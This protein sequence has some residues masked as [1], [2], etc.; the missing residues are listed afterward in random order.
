MRPAIPPVAE[1]LLLLVLLLIAYCVLYG[2]FGQREVFVVLL[3]ITNTGVSSS[4]TSCVG[5]RFCLQQIGLSADRYFARLVRLI[6]CVI[7]DHR[8]KESIET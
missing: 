3:H 2:W 8:H 5:F 1:R 4:H 7:K 6:V